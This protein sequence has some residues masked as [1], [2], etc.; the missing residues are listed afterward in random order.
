MRDGV[1]YNSEQV[2][3]VVPFVV[4]DWAVDSSAAG[5]LQVVVHN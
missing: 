5:N 1:V 3:V 4:D 2:A